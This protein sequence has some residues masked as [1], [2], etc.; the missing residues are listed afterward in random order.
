MPD[1][2]FTY[3]KVSEVNAGRE[4][5]PVNWESDDNGE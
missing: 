3:L 4:A 1:P 5:S 2:R